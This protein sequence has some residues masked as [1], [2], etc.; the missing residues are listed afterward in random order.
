MK[1]STLEFRAGPGAGLGCE[2]AATAVPGRCV[3]HLDFNRTG[4]TPRD[5]EP[6]CSL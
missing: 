3:F 4:W 1:A 2:P 5:P 6:V